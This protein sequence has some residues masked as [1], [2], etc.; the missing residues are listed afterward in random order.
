MRPA[1]DKEKQ[2]IRWL[3]LIF[4]TLGIKKWNILDGNFST[5]D[6][7]YLFIYSLYLKQ[8]Y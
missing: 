4:P 2:Q 1:R 7:F 6:E 8:L 5:S 3:E